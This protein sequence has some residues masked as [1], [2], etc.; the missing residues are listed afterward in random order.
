MITQTHLLALGAAF[1]LGA[2]TAVKLQELAPQD[3]VAPDQATAREAARLED[4]GTAEAAFSLPGPHHE[5]L[6]SLIGSWDLRGRWRAT[7]DG[8]WVEFEAVA[9]REWLYDGRYVRE[10]VVSDWGGE[11]FEATAFLGYDNVREEYVQVWLEN[12]STGVQVSTGKADP[13]GSTI[14]LEGVNSNA[15]T[16]EKDVWQRSVMTFAEPDRTVYAGFARDAGGAQ[17]QSLS[18]VADRR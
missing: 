15:M 11:A 4:T 9:E 1:A 18:M 6:G 8:E 14:T 16:G 17:F 5:R 7:P 13:A 12:A 2:T 10:T 3:P